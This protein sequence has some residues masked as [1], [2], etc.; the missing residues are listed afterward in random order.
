MKSW[1]MTVTWKG[2]DCDGDKQDVELRTA[3][4][5]RALECAAA[6]LLE[7]AR[8]FNREDKTELYKH[9]GTVELTPTE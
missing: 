3:D 1:T 2:G 6:Q 9:V 5:V 7:W 4:P 8:G